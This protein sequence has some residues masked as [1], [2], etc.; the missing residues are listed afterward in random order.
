MLSSFFKTSKP[1]HYIITFLMVGIMVGYF[2]IDHPFLGWK[3]I[4]ISFLAI[5]SIAIFQFITLKNELTHNN[6]FSLWIYSCLL[7][8]GLVYFSDMQIFIAYNCLLLALRRLLSMRTT[9]GLV[10]KIFDASLWV[11]IA[12]LFHSW[13]ALFFIIIFLS[14]VIY[15][16]KNFNYWAVPFIA[17]N[18]VSILA[19]TV[20]QYIGTNIFLRIFKKFDLSFYY[21]NFEMDVLF[22]VSSIVS[23][24]GLVISLAFLFG[25]PKIPISARSRFSVLG[26]SGI[27]GFLFFIMNGS[28]LLL[29]PLLSI[30]T[31]RIVQESQNKI[32]K[33][34]LLWIPF[35]TMIVLFILRF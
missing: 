8:I 1:I 14:I 6:S 25:F 29:V 24:V 21:V 15:S 4:W 2:V 26:F 23:C 18:C 22:A 13:S 31:A 20:D 19:F 5:V 33:E 10:R 3:F 17:I 35:I 11:S 7:V 30:F 16:F 12:T 32:V 27:C 9:I 28:A 34:F